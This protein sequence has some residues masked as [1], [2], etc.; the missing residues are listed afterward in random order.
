MR[1][2][3]LALALGSLLVAILAPAT[4]AM[5]TKYPV[6]AS[7]DVQ[8]VDPGV[9]TTD[10]A[11]YYSVRGQEASQ[12]VTF[13]YPQGG[14][15]SE[16]TT[17]HEVSLV[18]F[19][20][21]LVTATGVLWGK[22]TITFPDESTMNCSL[23]GTFAQDFTYQFLVWSGDIVCHGTGPLRGWQ[24]RFDVTFDHGD[25]SSAGYIFLPGDKSH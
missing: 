14:P 4:L 22:E 12:D 18:N 17:G 24:E 25:A 13:T 3:C 10:Y 5:T 7:A 2:L 20:L 15:G 21:D 1:R 11:T 8:V 23:E 19:D 6:Q 9:I 16:Y